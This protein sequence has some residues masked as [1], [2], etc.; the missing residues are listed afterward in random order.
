MLTHKKSNPLRK[1]RIKKGDEV[2]LIAGGEKGKTGIVEKLDLKHSKIIVAGVNVKKRHQ[3]PDQQGNLG[4]IV[5]KTMP[6]AISNVAFLDPK[7]KKPTR[8]SFKIIDG[9]KKRV[10]T[11]SQT[12]L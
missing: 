9:E 6:V 8:I 12:V 1:C 2:I 5:D 7:T 11:A 4:G 10:C 3:K